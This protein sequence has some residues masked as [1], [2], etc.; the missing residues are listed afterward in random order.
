MRMFTDGSWS[1]RFEVAANLAIVVASA[2][3]VLSLARNQLMVSS[4]PSG[5]PPD[6]DL[7]VGEKVV[8]PDV[9]W[10][11]YPKTLLFVLQAGCHFCT[12][13]APFYQRVV[14]STDSGRVRLIAVFPAATA[15]GRTYL[16]SMGLEIP[17]LQADLAKVRIRGTPTLLLVNHEGRL[18]KK[19]RGRLSPAQEEVLASVAKQPGTGT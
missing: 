6:R 19:W 17:G 10:R 9:D 4:R 7:A 14:A 11:A 13:S 8:L 18:A 15:D 2:A 5:S 16:R 1:R 12:E 3:L